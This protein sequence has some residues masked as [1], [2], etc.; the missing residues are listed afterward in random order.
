MKKKF[1][2]WLLV[3][4]FSFLSVLPLNLVDARN[5]D[6]MIRSPFGGEVLHGFQLVRV[7]SKGLNISQK[8]LLLSII[9]TRGHRVDLPLESDGRFLFTNLDTRN[10]VDGTHYLIAWARKDDRWAG[11]SEMI[12]VV[13]DN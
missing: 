7:E 9:D 12:S 11:D 5:K 1:I 13:I 3:F 6:L 4:L 8:D 10:W 2:L